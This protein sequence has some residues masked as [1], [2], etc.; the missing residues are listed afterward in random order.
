MLRAI[1][2]PTELKV[3]LCC[4]KSSSISRTLASKLREERSFISI[5]LS[6]LLALACSSL[7]SFSPGRLIRNIHG[8]QFKNTVRTCTHDSN[9]QS[10][11]VQS[12]LFCYE[13]RQAV[14]CK[15]S[16]FRIQNSEFSW[17]RLT[18]LD[19]L[20][21]HLSYILANLN[22]NC[23][24]LITCTCTTNRVEYKLVANL[25]VYAKWY[26]WCECCTVLLRVNCYMNA[27]SFG[28]IIKH[29]ELLPVGIDSFQLA[30]KVEWVT[31]KQLKLIVCT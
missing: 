25:H 30:I 28:D 23:P 8:N 17:L 14:L 31:N 4:R 20:Q 2:L 29:T 18:H 5:S 10:S 21:L 19:W 13:R 11:L 6:L 12:V 26:C 9:D 3:Q 16:F 1:P 24:T 15:F 22:A 27:F 7:C